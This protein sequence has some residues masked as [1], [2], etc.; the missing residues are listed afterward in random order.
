MRMQIDFYPEDEMSILLDFSGHTSLPENETSELL[1]LT[2]FTLRQLRDLRQHP[3]GQAPA[4]FLITKSCVQSAFSNSLELPSGKTLLDY[5]KYHAASVVS[6]RQRDEG[7]IEE[8]T[9]TFIK[10]SLALDYKMKYD[11]S[12]LRALD[13]EII[14]NAPELVEFRGNGKQSLEVT[15]PRFSLK[16]RGFGLLGWN[17]NHHAFHS[18][19]GLIRFLGSKHRADNLYLDHVIGVASQCGT[20][21]VFGQI[22]ADQAALA[23]AIL[24]VVGVP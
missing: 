23:I 6:Q 1:M 17:L 20:A 8:S 10:A 13:T 11:S 3:A 5:Q 22:P 14:A 15:L 7:S 9:N 12:I 19:I 18:V 21:S 24:D 2:C 4:G 16:L